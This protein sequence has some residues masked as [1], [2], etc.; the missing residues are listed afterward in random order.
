M[1][2]EIKQ[3]N[4]LDVLRSMDS[5]SVQT[6]VTSPPYWSLRDYGIPGQIG[7]EDTPD[8]FASAL[9][10]IFD[11]VRRVLKIRPLAPP[12][13]VTKFAAKGGGR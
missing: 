5:E 11:E 6:C 8:M 1:N 2:F 4:A 7:W 3:G 13:E 9:A 12:A 10:D